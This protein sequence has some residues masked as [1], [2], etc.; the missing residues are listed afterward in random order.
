LKGIPLVGTFLNILSN[1]PGYGTPLEDCV[2][3][4]AADLEKGLKSEWI[5]KRVSV[6]VKPKAG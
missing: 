2:D 3:F 4:I 5:G 1:M 6:K